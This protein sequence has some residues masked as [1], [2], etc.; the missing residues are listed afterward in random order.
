MKTSSKRSL[1]AS[2]RFG[3]RSCI[4]SNKFTGRTSMK[5]VRAISQR[6]PLSTRF[7]NS[8]AFVE[9]CVSKVSTGRPGR[10]DASAN[11][12][13]AIV[14]CPMPSGFPLHGNFEDARHKDA[15]G[16]ARSTC[17]HRQ[18]DRV[19]STRNLVASIPCFSSHIGEPK[20]I[21]LPKFYLACSQT[22]FMITWNS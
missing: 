22:C 17:W 3:T 2:S 13:D 4:R 5:P 20:D 19:V 12:S 7:V 14:G 9:I 21:L 6:K 11:G 8:S 10:L 1:V 15:P 18:V 16:T